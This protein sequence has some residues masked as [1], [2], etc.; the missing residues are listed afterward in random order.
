VARNP[1]H[2][3]RQPNGRWHVTGERDG[4]QVHC[5]IAG[6]GGKEP[7][8]KIVTS[9]PEEGGPGVVKNPEEDEDG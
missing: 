4:V 8:G 1:D 3:E 5:I 9:Y 7:E 6:K 2:A